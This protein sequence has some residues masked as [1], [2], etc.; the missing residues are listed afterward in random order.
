MSK[1]PTSTNRTG[2]KIGQKVKKAK[3]KPS[4][5]RWIERHI[6]DPYVQRAKLEGYRA[7]AAGMAMRHEPDFYLGGVDLNVFF[8]I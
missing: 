7:R 6:N 2:R 3:L 5:R 1:A 8:S 4:S